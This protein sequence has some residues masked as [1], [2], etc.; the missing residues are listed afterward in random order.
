MMD[1]SIITLSRAAPHFLTEVH[2]RGINVIRIIQSVQSP[3]LTF[4]MRSVSALGTEYFYI[5][6]GLFIFWCLSAKKGFR[7]GLLIIVSGW[8]NGFL[9]ILFNQPRP[10]EF[11]PELGLAFEP[12]RGFPSGHAQMSM[13]FIIAI[14]FYLSINKTCKKF[15]PLIWIAAVFAVLLM[16]L[17]RLYLGVH[18]P[19]DL[20]GGWITAAIILVS[21]YFLEKPAAAFFIEKGKRFQLI[22]TAAAALVMN[23]LHP[24]DIGLSALFLGFCAGYSILINNFPFALANNGTGKHFCLLLRMLRFIPGTI[25]A[26]AIFFGLRL[27]LPGEDSV[28]HDIQFLEP[29]Y[30]LGRFLRY[31]LFGLWASGGAPRV[32]MNLGLAPN[33]TPAVQNSG[34]E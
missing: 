18:F 33:E 2:D 30:D 8:I 5:F 9:K 22:F 3:A 25:G 20:F 7:L 32:F 34:D 17:S 29:Y 24:A 4:F 14:A 23:G 6:A 13:S 16:G 27:I 28:F 10:Y 21:F 15:R 31:G 12:T 19:T 11:Y 1:E 26:A